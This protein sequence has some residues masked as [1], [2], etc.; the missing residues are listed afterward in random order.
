M[1]IV[2]AL[3]VA[4]GNAHAFADHA[5]PQAQPCAEHH[6]LDS[7]HH[8]SHGAAGHQE[9]CC[10]CFNCPASLITPFEDS[11]PRPAA[12]ASRLTP[13]RAA[14]LA[15]RFLPPELDPPRPSALS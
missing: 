8:Q 15:N 6:H 7:D 11:P 9:C 5:A 12:Y 4:G 13:D 3:F 10:S 1:L 14:P 2:A